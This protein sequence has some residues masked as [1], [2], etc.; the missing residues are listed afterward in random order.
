MMMST[1]IRVSEKTRDTVHDLA[2]NVGVPMAEIVERAIEQ[3]RRQHILDAA[4]A[5]YAALRADPE[6]WAEI[7]AERALWDATLADG[8]EDR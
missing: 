3:Y 7:E 6:A 8:L 2:R 4:N 5:Q 1:T